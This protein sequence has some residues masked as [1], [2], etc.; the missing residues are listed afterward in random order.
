[1]E[2][3]L[4]KRKKT[5]NDG[6]FSIFYFLT[7]KSGALLSTSTVLSICGGSLHQCN[8]CF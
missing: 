3:Y 8:V 2:R 1:M 6:N 4:R 5:W 7:V